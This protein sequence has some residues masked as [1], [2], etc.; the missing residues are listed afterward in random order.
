MDTQRRSIITVQIH[1][2][3]TDSSQYFS[4]QVIVRHVWILEF[5]WSAKQGNTYV[6][7]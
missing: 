5:F 7:I 2:G 3:K 6:I 4:G 1:K